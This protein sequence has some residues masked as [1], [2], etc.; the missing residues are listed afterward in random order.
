MAS[1]ARNMPARPAVTDDK[2]IALPVPAAAA[3]PEV[4]LPGSYGGHLASGRTDVVGEED[5]LEG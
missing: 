1:L 3:P 2:A 5:E 4:G